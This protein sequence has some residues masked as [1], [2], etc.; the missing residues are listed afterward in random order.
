MASKPKVTKAPKEQPKAVVAD[1]ILPR[2][3]DTPVTGTC[4]QCAY[5]S[6]GTWRG[7]TCVNRASPEFKKRVRDEDTCDEFT[8]KGY[9][10]ARS[11]AP[12]QEPDVTTEGQ[13]DPTPLQELLDR[14]TE[15]A[16]DG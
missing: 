7:P 1:P 6:T 12:A 3:D 14:E 10:V 13:Y 11:A 2:T 9:H 4:L 16:K 8:P 5:L 15:A